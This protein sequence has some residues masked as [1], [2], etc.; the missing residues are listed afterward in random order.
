MTFSVDVVYLGHMKTRDIHIRISEEKY[1]AIK[2]LAKKEYR[3]VTAVID[4]ALD[5]HLNLRKKA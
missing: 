2:A 5:K 4:M 3:K 1:T